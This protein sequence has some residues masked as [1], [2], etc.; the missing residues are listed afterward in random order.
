[1]KVHLPL[2][3]RPERHRCR[4]GADVRGE[5]V[6]DSDNAVAQ[7]QFALLKPL[8]LKTIRARGTVQSLDGDIQIAV[9]LPQALQQSDQFALFLVGHA[10][11]RNA[12]GHLG[13]VGGCRSEARNQY[14]ILNTHD[15]GNSQARSAQA[16]PRRAV[17]HGAPKEVGNCRP[18]L[19]GR[20]SLRVT[21][22]F[23]DS[24]DLLRRTRVGNRLAR[25]LVAES[26][27]LG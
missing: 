14:K 24:G 5:L 10:W 13:L 15:F 21:G 2:A 23:H 12:R 17:L 3:F 22:W 6:F 11:T 7:D 20:S 1:M 19:K 18:F 8:D 25:G 4:S 26:P 9:F 16:Q 27:S